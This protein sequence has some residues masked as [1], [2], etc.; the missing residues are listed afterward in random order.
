MPDIIN[1]VINNMPAS[2]HN[3]YV[4]ELAPVNQTGLYNQQWKSFGGY[5]IA[6]NSTGSRSHLWDLYL[7]SVS[8][9]NNT[10]LGNFRI[11]RFS[12]R[13]Y[14]PLYCL[15]FSDNA[16]S[17]VYSPIPNFSKLNQLNHPNFDQY[18]Y[19][20]SFSFNPI[21]STNFNQQW[22]A[23]NI[24]YRASIVPLYP[25]LFCSSIPTHK[26]FGPAFLNSF[27]I[28][29]DGMENLGDVEIRCSVSGGRSVISPDN[30][31]P[32]RPN[33]DN[34]VIKMKNLDNSNEINEF[35]NYQNKYRAIN[36]SDCAFWPGLFLNPN[37]FKRTV[38]NSYNS[39]V[40]PPYKIVGMS[41]RI[42]QQ[43]NLL[44][45]YPGYSVLNSIIDFGDI[46]GPRFASLG[47]RTVSGTIKLFSP[48]NVSL[49]NTNASSLTMFFGS[50]FYYTMKNV[51]WQQPSITI[52]P[53][54][55]YFIEYEFIARMTEITYFNGFN[56][57]R[58]SEFL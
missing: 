57:Y 20:G 10:S 29:V 58:V 16:G 39:N 43:V 36:L 13:D 8:M 54:N 21:L 48:Q 32:K 14:K 12:E 25:L 41:L 45:T 3:I 23:E 11:K 51:D 15:N 6:K 52:N 46:L 19:T 26:S 18:K 33:L 50:A 42:Q 9:I 22:D 28:S 56:N 44:F 47:D 17:N 35:N 55:G 53:G 34:N 4:C 7:L 49:I 1:N 24:I 40:M 5:R 37:E 27:E 2:G 30:I 31:P 38:Q